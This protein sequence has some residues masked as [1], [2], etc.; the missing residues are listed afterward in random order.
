M[1]IVN[2]E[3]VT[4]QREIWKNAEG[5]QGK[6]SFTHV[7]APVC[8]HVWPASLWHGS[9]VVLKV[10]RH[11]SFL[12]P[13]STLKNELFFMFKFFKITRPP[14]GRQTQDR[15]RHSSS[16]NRLY[17][18]SDLCT[19]AR[20]FV[21]LSLH[22]TSA[23]QSERRRKWKGP[24]LSFLHFSL[25]RNPGNQVDPLKVLSFFHRV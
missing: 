13:N 15:E 3:N 19:R 12:V 14:D 21:I 25:K 16:E 8:A 5:S 20:S 9:V 1:W 18:R 7:W 2:V 11:I 17:G 22:S 6:W 10:R 4:S 23:A 24:P